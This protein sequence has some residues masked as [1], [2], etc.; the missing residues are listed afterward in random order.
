MEER[1]A[2]PEGRIS[3]GEHH[4]INS[5]AANSVDYDASL[6]SP[7]GF[8]SLSAFFWLDLGRC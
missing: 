3:D 8:V 7:V 6:L 2:V 1:N 5:L 4:C